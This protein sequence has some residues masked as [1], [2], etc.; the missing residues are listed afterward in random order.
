MYFVNVMIYLLL[1]YARSE[2]LI[3]KIS[4]HKTISLGN[5]KIPIQNFQVKKI[6]KNI[7][8]KRVGNSTT[9]KLLRFLFIPFSTM[10]KVN[11][12]SM[13]MKKKILL[14]L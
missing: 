6:E 5:P 10:E 13:S 3:H 12:L 7:T 4:E 2:F 11:G 9:N 14:N 8:R 1:S